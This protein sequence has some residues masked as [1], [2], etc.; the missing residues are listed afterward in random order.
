MDLEQI[1]ILIYEKKYITKKISSTKI[2]F[3]FEIEHS[4]PT[5]QTNYM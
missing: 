2:Y 3:S 1:F 5:D 4:D